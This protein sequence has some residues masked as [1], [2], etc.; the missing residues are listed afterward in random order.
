MV[1][2]VHEAVALDLGQGHGAA[3]DRLDTGREHVAVVAADPLSELTLS[4]FD[5]LDFEGVGVPVCPV[6]VP[7]VA[8]ERC[9][10]P[11]GELSGCDEVLQRVDGGR[12][13]DDSIS[14]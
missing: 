4:R 13:H 11:G 9:L 2:D 14:G 5:T 8:I 1:R 12:G 6:R 7:E 10:K 3:G